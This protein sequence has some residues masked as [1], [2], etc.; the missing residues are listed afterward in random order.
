MSLN[1]QESLLRH[2]LPAFPP[3]FFS[4]SCQQV[5]PRVG[6]MREQGSNGD[7][8]MA[9]AFLSAGFEVRARGLDSCDQYVCPIHATKIR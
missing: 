2:S 3:R 5:K 9:A 4:L 6:V 8:E 1:I 7:R